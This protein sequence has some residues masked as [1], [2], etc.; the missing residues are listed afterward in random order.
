MA[1]S[2]RITI[3][4]PEPL[5]AHLSDRIGQG[6]T[7]SDI[8]RQALEAYFFGDTPREHPGRPTGHA[9]V[10]DAITTLS[11]SVS[12]IQRSLSDVVSDV[13]DMRH[14]LAQLEQRQPAAPRPGRTPAVT[15]Q[16]G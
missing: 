8:V 15:R 5:V 7:M 2:T 9:G 3:R 16:P 13:A 11:D 1:G 14:R 12:D 4:L 10:S 6:A